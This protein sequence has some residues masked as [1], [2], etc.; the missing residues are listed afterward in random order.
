M[1]LQALKVWGA[2]LDDLKSWR[3][4]TLDKSLLNLAVY[5]Y[6]GDNMYQSHKQD[7]VAIETANRTKRANQAKRK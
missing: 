7:A 4:G 6:I 1:E 2:T 5:F 3:D